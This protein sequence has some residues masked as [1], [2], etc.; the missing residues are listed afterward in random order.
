M[1]SS[2]YSHH[3]LTYSNREPC[4]TKPISFHWCGTPSQE[5]CTSSQLHTASRRRQPG[6]NNG[7]GRPLSYRQPGQKYRDAWNSIV[8]LH[9]WPPVLY[10]GRTL[11]TDL[12]SHQHSLLLQSLPRT[13]AAHMPEQC[14]DYRGQSCLTWLYDLFLFSFFSWANQDRMSS[15]SMQA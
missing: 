8:V 4:K 6:R 2:E 11:L 5:G 1:Q 7:A 15:P 3:A 12:N 13:Q 10:I 14:K 9:I